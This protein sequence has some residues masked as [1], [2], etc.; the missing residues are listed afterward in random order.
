MTRIGLVG[1][2]SQKRTRPAPARVLYVSALFRKASEYAEATCDRWYVLSAK[3]G[4]VHPDEVLAPYNVKLGTKAG[5][6]IWDWADR[7]AGQLHE[8]LAGVED[9]HLVVL[10]GEQYR[11]VLRRVDYPHEVPMEGLMLGEQLRWLTTR[12][13]GD[14][15]V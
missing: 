10:A 2:A 7:V 15:N 13:G 14:P 8:T 12:S 6:P 11:T 9:P 1:C 5:P 3:H 4:L